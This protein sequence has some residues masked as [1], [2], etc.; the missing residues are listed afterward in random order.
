MLL[1]SWG[2]GEPIP[3]TADDRV[4]GRLYKGARVG[5]GRGPREGP[6]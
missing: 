6:G 3:G 2:S 5:W 4:A 1:G